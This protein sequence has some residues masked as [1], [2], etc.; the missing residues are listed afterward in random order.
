MRITLLP[1]YPRELPV[2]GPGMRRLRER[3][4]HTTAGAYTFAMVSV[5]CWRP[6][7]GARGGEGS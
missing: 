6:G 7:S 1:A 5:L 4:R 3:L 2:V